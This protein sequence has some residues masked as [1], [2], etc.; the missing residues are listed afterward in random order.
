VRKVAHEVLKGTIELL[1]GGRVGGSDDILQIGGVDLTCIRDPATGRPYLPGSSLKGRMR[2]CLEKELGKFTKDRDGRNREPC[3]C[4]R[5]DC[6]VCV[7]F[8]PHK[9]TNHELGPTRIIVRDAPLVTPE[10]H[11][12]NKTE[13]VNRRDTGAAEHP[14]TVERVAPGAKFAF[15][16]AVQS[17]DSD[18]RVRYTDTDGKPVQGLAALKEVVEHALTLVEDTGIGAGVGKGYGK[19]KITI[20]Q[21]WTP[22]RRR[23]LDRSNGPQE[24]AGSNE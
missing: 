16:I 8:G 2:S 21:D 1:S 3:G 20:T 5:W 9:N 6:P 10:F 24:S 18:E 17:Y 13:S 23:R 14:R 15:E 12:E 19:V 4:A 7:V 22:L 11:I